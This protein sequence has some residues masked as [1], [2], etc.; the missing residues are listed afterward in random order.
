M[1]LLLKG[2]RVID[3]SQNLDGPL[4]LFIAEGKIAAIAERIVVESWTQSVS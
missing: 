2:G 1:K 3:P 4:E